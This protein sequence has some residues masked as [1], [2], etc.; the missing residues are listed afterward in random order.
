[1]P[2]SGTP[3]YFFRTDGSPLLVAGLWETA[4]SALTCTL[5]TADAVGG[6][7]VDRMPLILGERDW[8][9]WLDPDTPAPADLLATPPDIGGIGN[10][11]GVHPRQPGRQQRAGTH[12]TLRPGN[13]PV[14]LF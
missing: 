3:F 12:R 8:D 14:G 9:R 2:G 11:G 1:M 6:R 4:E 5:I 7:R 13:Q 10:A